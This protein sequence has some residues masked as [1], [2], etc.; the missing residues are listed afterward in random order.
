MNLN[1]K[2]TEVWCHF[3]QKWHNISTETLWLP[4]DIDNRLDIVCMEQYPDYYIHLGYDSDLVE[5]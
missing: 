4:R 5:E 3:C 1:E 2:K